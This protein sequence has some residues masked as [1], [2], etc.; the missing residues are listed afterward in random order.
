MIVNEEH[1]ANLIRLA[2]EY[3]YSMQ[4]YP[5]D[6]ND[7]PKE[8]YL[9]YLSLMYEPEIVK[10]ILEFPIMPKMISIKKVAN[11]LN[12][13]KDNLIKKL[14]THVKRGFIAKVGNRYARPSPLQIHDLPFILQENLDREDVIKFAQLSR[15]YFEDGYYKTWETSRKG[16]PRTRVLTVS[17]KV[18]PGH[19]IMPMEEVYR[20]IDK[21]TDFIVV[22]CPCRQRKEVEGIRKCKDKYPIH[23]CIIFGAFAKGMLEIGDLAVKS[24][25]KEEVKR[26]TREAAELG[27]VHMTDN[28][29]DDSHILCAC[30]E[31][32]CGNLAGLIRFRDNPRAIARANYISSVDPDL[33]ASCGTCM[34]RCKFDAIT[35]EDHAQVNPDKCVGCGLCAITCPEDAIT[36]KRYEREL[37]PSLQ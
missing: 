16:T 29:A 8:A 9:E 6:E 5:A 27:L 18:E 20:I 26:I 36:M 10:L 17:E 25:T 24:I 11:T 28:S 31:C 12:M 33:C 35:I 34:E 7:E 3:K 19:Q 14:E 1:K 30:C 23:N 4:S 22:P 2:K 21:Q 13:D 37:I 32:C 15:E